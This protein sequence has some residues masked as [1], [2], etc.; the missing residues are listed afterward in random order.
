MRLESRA[1]IVV[2]DDGPRDC[3]I[4]GV[5]MDLSGEYLT[6]KAAAASLGVHASTLSRLA[7]RGDVP[8]YRSRL[9]RRQKFVKRTDIERLAVIEPVNTV[10]RTT[11]SSAKS[12]VRD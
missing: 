6:M 7:Q 10:G 8:V 2:D 1:S 12:G 5:V 4:V 9:N 11:A 3:C